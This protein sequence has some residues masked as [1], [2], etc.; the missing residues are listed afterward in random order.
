MK[1]IRKVLWALLDA[2]WG[3]EMKLKY[4][5]NKYKKRM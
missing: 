1:H 5:K 4:W 2:T 3:Y